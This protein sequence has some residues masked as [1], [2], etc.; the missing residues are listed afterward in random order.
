MRIGAPPPLLPPLLQQ[1][2]L[3]TLAKAGDGFAAAPSADQQAGA[4]L[5]PPVPLPVPT[6]TPPAT[7]VQ[8]LVA[9]AA[10]E[11]AIERRRKQAAAADAG[12][13]LLER[14]HAELT[15]GTPAP[16]RLRELVEWSQDLDTPSDP[17]LATLQ[18]EVELRVRVELA[19]HD[20][21]V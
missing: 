13:S 18:R 6:P 3:A 15:V 21:R 8:M 12:L 11:P 4:I 14:L 10:A 7:S 19:K 17:H 16:E 9:L 2:L 20:M 5:P 1:A